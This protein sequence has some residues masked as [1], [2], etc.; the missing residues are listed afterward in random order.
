MLPELVRMLPVGDDCGAGLGGTATVSLCHILNSLSLSDRQHARAIVNEGALPRIVGISRCEGGS[1]G[2]ARSSLVFQKTFI[3][4]GMDQ[5]EWVRQHVSCCTPCGSTV[6]FTG[7]TKRSVQNKVY[8]RASEC[9]SSSI[10]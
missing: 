10:G 2:A 9:L 7:P 4:L 5:A 8:F 6:T 1:A 3:L